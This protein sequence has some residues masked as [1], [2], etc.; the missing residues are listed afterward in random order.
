MHRPAAGCVKAVNWTS[1][2]ARAWTWVKEPKFV[3]EVIEAKLGKDS[4]LPEPVAWSV[5]V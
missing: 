2:P 1:P 4:T 5:S 3:F